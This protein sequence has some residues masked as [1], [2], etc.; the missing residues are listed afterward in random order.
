[1]RYFRIPFGAACLIGLSSG[2]MPSVNAK[3]A[4][5]SGNIRGRAPL[6]TDA[7]ILELRALSQFAG[8]S[9]ARLMKRYGIDEHAA[10]RFLSGITR[11]RL[12]AKPCHLPA[13][14]TA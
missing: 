8:W 3:P 14:I 2:S 6:L 1:M 7:Q 12:V 9:R 5:S 10:D 11:S 4:K 13:E